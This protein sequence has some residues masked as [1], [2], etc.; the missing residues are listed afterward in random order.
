V[1]FFDD[2]PSTRNEVDRPR[3]RYSGVA[4]DVLNG[5]RLRCLHCG[6]ENV[7]SSLPGSGGRLRVPLCR[8]HV[9]W[10]LASRR[11][12]IGKQAGVLKRMLLAWGDATGVDR[13]LVRDWLGY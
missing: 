2:T 3:D 8:K 9:R 6:S 11:E 1:D 4:A 13:A 7:C 10:A 5:P 12:R